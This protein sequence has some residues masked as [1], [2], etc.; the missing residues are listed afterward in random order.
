MMNKKDYR[1]CEKSNFTNGIH[2]RH[3]FPTSYFISDLGSDLKS[4][5]KLMTSTDVIR[6]Y[7]SLTNLSYLTSAVTNSMHSYM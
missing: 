2:Y 7:K 3:R 4:A 6:F 5:N 1:K